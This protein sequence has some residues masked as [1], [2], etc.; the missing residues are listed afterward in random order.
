MVLKGL[1]VLIRVTAPGRLLEGP[2]D[3]ASLRREDLITVKLG[4]HEPWSTGGWLK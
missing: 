3:V 4:T 2:D 1:A